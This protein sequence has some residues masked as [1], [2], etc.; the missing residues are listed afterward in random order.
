MSMWHIRSSNH[1]RIHSSNHPSVFHHACRVS[2]VKG[3][4]HPGHV[5]S[6]SQSHMDKQ[7]FTHPPRETTKWHFFF[8]SWLPFGQWNRIWTGLN[9]SEL[10][11]SGQKGIRLALYSMHLLSYKLASNFCLRKHPTLTCWDH[12]SV[13]PMQL[14]NYMNVIGYFNCQESTKSRF[15]CKFYTV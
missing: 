14:V 12:W 2:G 10:T 4:P 6:L 11:C 15:M 5:G 9:D 1:L 13:W 8:S 7:S 3:R